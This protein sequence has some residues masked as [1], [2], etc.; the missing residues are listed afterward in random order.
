MTS[1]K[2]SSISTIL[3]QKLRQKRR[4]KKLKKL[5]DDYNL[6]K[7]F[8]ETED[9]RN[10]PYFSYQT[11]D[12]YFC[13]LAYWLK[14]DLLEK[15]FDPMYYKHPDY[16][17]K[18]GH[19]NK[20]WE[21]FV[22]WIGIDEQGNILDGNEKILNGSLWHKK[23]VEYISVQIEDRDFITPRQA[24]DLLRITMNKLGKDFDY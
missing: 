2:P 18:E 21:N 11:V 17:L 22:F 4:I 24:L 10:P 1:S 12:Y 3:S 23:Y 7:S 20:E 13:P 8:L 6:F 14:K 5:Y 16:E 19:R 15:V 9:K